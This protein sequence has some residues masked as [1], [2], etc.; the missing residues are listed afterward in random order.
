M[1]DLKNTENQK[2][3]IEEPLI[4]VDA[5]YVCHFIKHGVKGSLTY[6]NVSTEIIL[7]FML[8]LQRLARL[9]ES[10]RFAFAWDSGKSYRKQVFPFYKAN[11]TVS[12][13]PSDLATS[14]VIMRQFT[15]IRTEVLPNLGFQNNFIQ[16]GLEAD[17]IVA[18]IAQMLWEKK[19]VI[20]SVDSDLYQVLN[21][22]N[23]MWNPRTKKKYYMAH[24]IDDYKIAPFQ[25]ANVKAI[26]GDSTDN[27][28]G[29]EGVG[30]VNAVK[31]LRGEM[32]PDTK[33]YKAIMNSDQL[34]E[35][36][37]KLVKLPYEGTKIFTIKEDSFRVRDYIRVCETYGFQS[38]IRKDMLDRWTDLFDMRCKLY[39]WGVVNLDGE[40]VNAQ[41]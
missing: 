39:E 20:V 18:S 8:Q 12:K 9:F 37:Q 30:I 35:R 6:E 40:V 2:N 34:I 7:G 26:A 29:V 11:R 17:D 22:N 27:I 15:V 16:T 33:R 38:L 10:K 14:N 3:E 24:F 4:L 28:D 36:N 5:N 31:F 25:W 41:I 32:N 13:D 19:V 1:N 23:L 21:Q